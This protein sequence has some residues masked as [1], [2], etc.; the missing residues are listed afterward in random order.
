M[1]IKCHYMYNDVCSMPKYST[2][3]LYYMCVRVST[4]ETG[5]TQLCGCRYEHSENIIIYMGISLYIYSTTKH[6][7]KIFW[8]FWNEC[9][10]ITRV[11]WNV[12]D[13]RFWLII[14]DFTK[15]EHTMVKSRQMLLVTRT[16]ISIVWQTY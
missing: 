2:T 7:F 1:L 16:A 3:L 11:D 6:F 9:F 8:Q 10:R 5:N 12:S 4:L 13:S 14:S 15:T